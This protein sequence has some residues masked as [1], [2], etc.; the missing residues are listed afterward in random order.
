M[1]TGMNAM[2]ITKNVGKTVPAV[3]IGCHAGNRCCLNALSAQIIKLYCSLFNKD[4]LYH[5]PF[6]TPWGRAF[7]E[8]LIITQLFKKF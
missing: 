6:L 4:Y 8:K 1:P 5:Q 7:P 2:P 3:K